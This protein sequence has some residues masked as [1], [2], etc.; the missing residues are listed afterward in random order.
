M[1]LSFSMTISLYFYST[2]RIFIFI[3]CILTSFLSIFSS[4][5]ISTFCFVVSSSM[6]QVAWILSFSWV[7]ASISSVFTLSYSFNSTFYFSIYW[8]FCLMLLMEFIWDLT[9]CSWSYSLAADLISTSLKIFLSFS[10]ISSRFDSSF[11]W[12]FFY[13]RTKVVISSSSLLSSLPSTF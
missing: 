3:S 8:S 9:F 10:I 2:A 5:W 11:S 13:W 12:S 4:F 7:M 6:S 1:S